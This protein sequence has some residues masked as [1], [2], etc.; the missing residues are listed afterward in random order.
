MSKRPL[1]KRIKYSLIH[2]FVLA[3][4]HLVNLFPR[5]W[6]MATTGFLGGLA[7]HLFSDA[8][9]T[10]IKNLNKVYGD[11]KS[12]DEIRGLAKE[13]FK[14]IGRNAGDI[15]KGLFIDNIEDLGKVVKIDGEEHLKDAM[16]KGKGVIAITGHIGAF[17]FVGSYLGLADF[18][19]LIIGT[20]LKDERLNKLLIDQR[21]SRGSEA[22]ARGK[23]TL[24][25]IKGLKS[26]RLVLMLIDQDTKV[27]SRF[28]DFLGHQAATPIGGTL[29]ARRTGAVVVPMYITLQPDYSQLISIGPE[30]EMD[31]TEDEERDLLVNTKRISDT[32]EQAILRNP[33]QWVW[34]HERWKTKPGEELR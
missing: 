3:L 33:E 20:A 25:L 8:R 13:V 24:K 17:E 19:P 31:W 4:I 9:E 11:S 14:M 6:V 16:A 26:G 21:E 32:T 7:F 30:I 23:E 10:T 12:A 34:M 5:R 28:I 27:K 2:W 1:K 22:I 29:I 15:V 18:R